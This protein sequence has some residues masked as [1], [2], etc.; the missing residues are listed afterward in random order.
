MSR[1]WAALCAAV[2]VHFWRINPNEASK[3]HLH[4]VCRCHKTKRVRI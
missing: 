3:G 1:V 2:H 4:L